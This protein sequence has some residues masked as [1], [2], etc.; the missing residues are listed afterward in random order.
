MQI[1]GIPHRHPLT[2]HFLVFAASVLVAVG[3]GVL[4]ET[5]LAAALPAAL[6]VGWLALHDIR[7]LFYLMLACI[8][9]STEIELPGGL[10][11][12]L[13]SEPLMWLL[14]GCGLIWLGLHHRKVKGD[15]LRHPISWVLFA[16]LA[17]MTVCVATSQNVLVS[18]KFLLAKGWYLAVFYFWA[19]YLLEEERDF[20][21]VVWWFFVPLFVA[22]SIVNVRNA[23]QGFSFE[24][25]EYVMGP[26]FRNHVIFACVLAVFMP[27]VWY[28][29][30]WY[31]RWSLLWWVLVLGI[32]C[33]IFGINF[34]YT[35]AAYVSLLAMV[36][37]KWLIHWRQLKLGLL[38]FALALAVFVRF[39][40]TEDNWLRFAPDFE[41]AVTHKE[42][43]NL[44]EATTKLEDISVMERVYRWVACSY[45]IRER[46]LMGFGPGTFYRYYKD[47]T[48]TSFKT[49]VSDNPEKSGTHNYWIMST[50]EQ[51]FPGLV[52]FLLLIVF[53]LLRGE[54][55]YHET[56][57]PARRRILLMFLLCFAN[58]NLLM[59]MNDLVETDKFGSLFFMALAVLANLDLKN[60]NTAETPKL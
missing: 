4:Y 32:F 19:S 5:F 51:G 48:V 42:F 39:V 17:W 47:Y 54:R 56:A 10:G 29:T 43:T 15:L 46:P 16:H 2:A 38:A 1:P 8:P 50:V 36:G 25:V 6:I 58:I 3:L 23:A 28:A 33:F 24:K 41:R 14:T 55:I 21:N 40:A 27:F 31:R 60:R 20:K 45:M 30:Y 44:L 9:I 12:D 53:A 57:D 11:T 52:F 26:F 37:I 35:R 59:L 18:F 49:Y 7:R 34:A 13:P 22:C